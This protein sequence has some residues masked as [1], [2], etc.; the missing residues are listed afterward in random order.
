MDAVFC[1]ANKMIDT[2]FSLSAIPRCRQ[3]FGGCLLNHMIF[4]TTNCGHW[5]LL[6]V[7]M[8]PYAGKVGASIISNFLYI[9]RTF[10]P[11]RLAADYNFYYHAFIMNY[12]K[13]TFPLFPSQKWILRNIY[14]ENHWNIS[15]MLFSEKGYDYDDLKFVIEQFVKNHDALRLR[16]LKDQEGSYY[17][18]LVDETENNFAF[19]LINVSEEHDEN[20]FHNKMLKLQE[21]INITTGPLLVIG[22]FKTSR[23]D[24]LYVVTHHLISD[25]YSFKLMIHSIIFCYKAKIQEKPLPLRLSHPFLTS[26]EEL[27]KYSKS[28]AIKKEVDYWNKIVKSDL[29]PLRKDNIIKKNQRI[30]LN[31][32]DIHRTILTKEEHLAFKKVLRNFNI[33]EYEFYISLLGISLCDWNKSEEIIVKLCNHGRTWDFAPINLSKSQGPFWITYPFL[34]DTTQRNNTPERIKQIK[35]KIAQIPHNGKGYEVLRE[36]TLKDNPDFFSKDEVNPNIFINY[37]GK[38]HE[39]LIIEKEFGLISPYFKDLNR[40]PQAYCDFDL[41]F[42]IREINNCL[43]IQLIYNKLEYEYDSIN[44]LYDMININLQSSINEFNSK[45]PSGSYGACQ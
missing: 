12:E 8:A 25:A 1:T 29:K 26:V 24:H 38:I 27:Y 42:N 22:L 35:K 4:L 18:K 30:E 9:F 14:P 6:V 41:I 21:S 15:Y 36:I 13:N 23:G 17:Q 20:F 19:H 34:T 10:F 43:K 11:R 40:H 3:L 7:L 32:C 39:Y 45:L 28:E 33:S 44:N 31:N 5:E 37:Y 16:F 2:C